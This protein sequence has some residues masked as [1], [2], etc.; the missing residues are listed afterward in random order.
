M[1]QKQLL[2]TRF[3]QTWESMSI[4]SKN[5][6]LQNLAEAF[7]AAYIA[8]RITELPKI[9]QRM[10]GREVL[11]LFNQLKD[12]VDAK[13]RK[14]LTTA[15]YENFG[16][17][18]NIVG[19]AR[20]LGDW[21]A[22]VEVERRKE[23]RRV[24]LSAPVPTVASLPKIKK[25]EADPK[26]SQAP[27]LITTVARYPSEEKAL[28]GLY[29]GIMEH[30]RGV[31]LEENELIFDFG[32]G[33]RLEIQ[34]KEG[35]ELFAQAMEIGGREAIDGAILL[36]RRGMDVMD[37]EIATGSIW[38][39]E[40]N[41]N[42]EIY[43]GKSGLYGRDDAGMSRAVR[44][45]LSF[46]FFMTPEGQKAQKYY[47]KKENMKAAEEVVQ[48]VYKG[49]PY[50]LAGDAREAYILAMAAQSHLGMSEA[51][52]DGLVGKKTKRAANV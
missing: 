14:I 16:T 23:E 37:R 41:K 29:L 3:E 17:S 2:Q 51:E 49:N 21:A 5:E 19:Y 20:A 26:V 27:A 35:R 31:R 30:A 48:A 24:A 12:I 39:A 42:T 52:Q 25:E 10:S 8:G 34:I 40:G 7:Q 47:A 36:L 33:R 6:V 22:H 50:V 4:K 9:D 15:K 46:D 18:M 38:F 1:A 11:G 13:E 43:N 44:L 32:N 28:D 45:A